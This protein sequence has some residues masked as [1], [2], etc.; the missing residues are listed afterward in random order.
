MDS[1]SNLKMIS[2]LNLSSNNLTTINSNQFSNIQSLL[3]LNLANNQIISIENNTFCN[4]S[5]YTDIYPELF[6]QSN[7]LTIINSK[8]FT[9]IKFLSRLDLSKNEIFYIE[10]YS[11]PIL[12]YL[13]LDF[14]NL[15]II[16]S[17]HFSNIRMLY[18]LNLSNNKIIYIES[19]SFTNLN[20]LNVLDLSSNRIKFINQDY[21]LNNLEPHEFDQ[22]I[23]LSRN[24]IETIYSNSFS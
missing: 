14:N 9:N 23:D 22:H 8:H 16:N 18:Q 15:T 10:D 5:S 4:F 11:F 24:L 6:L 12:N 1:F 21:F 3:K 17:K 13:R 7:K 20:K 2:N 19:N